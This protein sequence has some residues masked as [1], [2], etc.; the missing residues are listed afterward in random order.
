[1]GKVDAIAPGSTVTLTLGDKADWKREYVDR[2]PSQE[3]RQRREQGGF[4]SIKQQRLVFARAR[5]VD[6]G[7]SG[8]AKHVAEVL[9]IEEYQGSALSRHSWI[10]KQLENFPKDKFQRLL[11]AMGG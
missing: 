2:I 11:D 9:G 7:E 8:V 10:A 4:I 3:D 1:M 5:G 6:G